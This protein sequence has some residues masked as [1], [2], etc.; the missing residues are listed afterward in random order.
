MKADH[1]HSDL[2]G[3]STGCLGLITCVGFSGKEAGPGGTGHKG[4]IKGDHSDTVGSVIG[5]DI[6]GDDTGGT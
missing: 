4:D 6:E 3:I 5:A 1:G 2:V